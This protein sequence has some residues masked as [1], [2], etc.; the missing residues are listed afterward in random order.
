MNIVNCLQIRIDTTHVIEANTKTYNEYM[1]SPTKYF[2]I[3]K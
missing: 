1:F 3:D 2:F